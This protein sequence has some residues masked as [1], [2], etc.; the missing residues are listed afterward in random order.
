VAFTYPRFR[1]VAFLAREDLK[2]TFLNRRFMK[3]AFLNLG[4]GTQPR[5]GQASR[6][7]MR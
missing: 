5:V 6:R 7:S 2:A 1:K 3:V 4:P